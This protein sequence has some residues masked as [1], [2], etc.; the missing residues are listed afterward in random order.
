MNK[1]KHVCVV[2]DDEL[3]Q[4][5]MRQ[6]FERLELVERIHKFTDGE[7]ALNY[8][9]SH[10]NTPDELPDLILLD[11]NMPYMDGWQFMREFVKLSLPDDKHIR[12][13]ILTSSTHESDLQ[14]ARE[15][16]GLAGY[17]VKP[18]G[19]NIIRELLMGAEQH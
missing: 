6:H 1:V 16:P 14:R 2:D 12:I 5:V 7:Q 18:I 19:K 15:F 11:V 9:K 3:F 4:F 17:L 13:Y 10:L 8:I